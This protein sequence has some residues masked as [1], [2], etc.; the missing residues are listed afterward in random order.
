MT[1]RRDE[2]HRILVSPKGTRPLRLPNSDTQYTTRNQSLDP[3]TSGHF[4]WYDARQRR[5]CR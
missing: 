2:G 5:I 1:R 3:L 4:A